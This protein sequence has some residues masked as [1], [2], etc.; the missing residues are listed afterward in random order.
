MKRS[1]FFT[2]LVLLLMLGATA[3]S[4]AAAGWM[5]GL[6]VAGWAVVFGLLTGTA[7]AFSNFTEWMAHVTSLIYGLF[8]IGVIGGTQPGISQDL[9]WRERVYVIF[10]KIVAW[11]RQALDN[12]TSRE[13]LIFVLIMCALFW[14]LSYTAAWYSFRHRRIW[15][16]LL[17]TGVTLF[18]NIYYYMGDVP[19]QPYLIVYLV[20]ALILLV[21]SYLADR[22]ER[23]L[24][25]HV[26]FARGLHFSFTMAGLGIAMVALLFAWRVPE[27][28]ASETANSVFG[29]L[30]TPYSELLARWNRLFSTLQNVNPQPVDSYNSSLVLSGPRH[31]TT[32]PVMDVTAPPMR[33]YWRAASYDYYDGTT[34]VS[35]VRNSKDLG[36]NDTSLTSTAYQDRVIVSPSFSMYRGTDSIYSPSVPQNAGVP[37]RGIYQT[38]DDGTVDIVQMRL[39][40]PLLPGNRYTAAGSMSIA[41]ADA[42]R[43]AP[44]NYPQWISETYLQLPSDIPREVKELAANIAG[45]AQTPYDKAHA[46]E[47]WLRTNITYDEDLEAPPPGVEGSYYILFRTKR[48]YCTY[49]A[50]AMVVMLRSQGVPARLVSG[51]AQGEVNATS[52]DANTAVYSVKNKDS[53]AWVEVYFPGYGWVEF[54]PTAGQPSIARTDSTQVATATPLAP[55]ATPQATAQPTPEPNQTPVVQP[56]GTDSSNPLSGLL[57][58][59]AGIGAALLNVLP[60]VL[61][62]VLVVAG[63]IFALRF[64]EGAGFGDLPPVQRT[65]A[66]LSRWATWLG[67]GQEHTPYE[68][69][70][71][72]QRRAPGAGSPTQTITR[73]YVANRFG[74]ASPDASQE[75]EALSSWERARREL[76]KTWLRLRWQRL[77]KRD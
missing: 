27:I 55:T 14:L 46:I 8:V 43:S 54:E 22:E 62:I 60:F 41:T 58:T 29:R 57:N 39:T 21:E 56:Q 63:G 17:P 53:H 69:A 10:E 47:Q 3:S 66:M 64:A 59:L 35:T 33:Y 40:S 71:E 2:L 28:A 5:P 48:A 72:L 73:L 38:T 42:L 15:H 74:A 6:E 52:G 31:L 37:A 20:C 34:W 18:A 16:V 4:I 25:D 49:Y 51:Y 50:T 77:T 67:I 76:H 32:D 30:N 75:K 13:S 44:A 36:A 61:V 12:G 7:L 9:T 26:R 65:Y 70:H 45:E 23:W 1:D 11:V 68:Q 19:M 24:R